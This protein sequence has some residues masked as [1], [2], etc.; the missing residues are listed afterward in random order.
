M[1]S[2]NGYLLFSSQAASAMLSE[3]LTCTTSAWSLTL[4]VTR[5][6]EQGRMVLRRREVGQ[7]MLPCQPLLVTVKEVQQKIKLITRKHFFL[8]EKCMKILK[9]R[10]YAKNC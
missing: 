3:R 5:E 6:P 9:V 8:M 2:D 10:L 7:R 1:L 4:G